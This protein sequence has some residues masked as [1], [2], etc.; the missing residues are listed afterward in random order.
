M[1]NMYVRISIFV[2]LM[3]LTSIIIIYIIYVIV[4]PVWYNG[5]FNMRLSLVH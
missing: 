5:I 4:N 3:H 1:N 2:V